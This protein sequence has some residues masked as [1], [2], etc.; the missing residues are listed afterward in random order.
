M[1]PLHSAFLAANSRINDDY[2]QSR[3][4]MTQLVAKNKMMDTKFGTYF[5][6]NFTYLLDMMAHYELIK[7]DRYYSTL[8][9]EALQKNNKALYADILPDHYDSS[10]VNPLYACEIFGKELGQVLSGIAYIL[11]EYVGL[12]YEGRLFEMYRLNKMMLNLYELLSQEVGANDIEKLTGDIKKV[13]RDSLLEGIDTVTYHE[14]IRQL[15]P[16]FSAYN[17]IA[18]ECELEDLRYLF[19]YGMYVSDNEILSA[20]FT[21]TLSE[22]EVQ[23]I[24]D[25]YTEAFARGFVHK[26]IDLG[27]KKS[28]LVTYHIGWERLIGRALK[29]LETMS[30]KPIVFYALRGTIRPR[31]YNTRPNLQMAY[32]HRFSDAVFF[33]ST[34]KEALMKA[35][36]GALAKLKDD[37]E[38][39]AGPALMEVFGQ[40]AFEPKNASEQMTHDQ[41][42]TDLKTAYNSER[43]AEYRRYVRGDNYSFTINAYPLP[44][45][46]KDYEAIFK[47]TIKVNTLDQVLYEKVQT[48]MIDA[49]D[50]ADYVRVTG[51][52]G[53]ETDLKVCFYALDNPDEETKF[54]NCTADVNVP[55]GEVFTTPLLAGT[56]GLLHVKEVYLR[57]LKYID[58]KLWFKDGMI[59]KYDCANFD[60]DV[61]NQNF[62]RETLMHPHTTLPI[63]EFAIGTNT[64]AYMMA[65][66]YNIGAILPIL[67]GEKTGPHFAVGDTCYLWGEENKVY[68]SNGK[69][70]VV[71]D[72]A[73]SIQRETDVS[74]AYLNKHTDITIPYDELDAIVGY[75]SDGASVTII[76]DGRF[77]LKGTEV[78]NEPFDEQ[79][80]I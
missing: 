18:M 47:D 38:V 12:C 73:I 70:I 20:K 71:K 78:L 65:K 3:I 77:V 63:G 68:N 26:G 64:V 25:T 69:E 14:W 37:A 59:S 7:E 75:K 66:K 80:K 15:S 67:I 16:E 35:H 46:G 13:T 43:M 21:Q 51:K 54:T 11:R 2:A 56:A 22:D 45:I 6:V 17:Y 33:D 34:Y 8:S 42:T 58:L 36:K 28:A 30:I 10:Y 44:S 4:E 52:N 31:L 49:L 55:V 19:R 1:K 50:Q 5:E 72:N 79:E 39:Y 32:D 57:G 27:Q 60:T 9:F 76:S 62:V 48:T 24:A 40:E 53:N 61:A 29:N 41:I 23:L 74:K